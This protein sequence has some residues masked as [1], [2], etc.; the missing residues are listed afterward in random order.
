[1]RALHRHNGKQIHLPAHLR[2]LDDRRKARQP[3]ANNDDPRICCHLR[4]PLFYFAMLDPASTRLAPAGSV[5]CCACDRKDVRLARPALVSTK[6]NAKQTTKNRFRALSP[7]TMP[8][9]AQN[10]QI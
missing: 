2:D 10:S 9:F 5:D 4:I 6:K 8:H 3:A 7:E 1:M